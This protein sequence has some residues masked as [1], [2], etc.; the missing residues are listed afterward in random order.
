MAGKDWIWKAFVA[1]LCGTG[2][3]A[4]LMY[5]KSRSGLLPLFRPYEALQATLG[6]L[7]GRDVPAAVPWLLSW[8]N[9]SAVLGFIFGRVYPL[10]PG[11]NGATKGVIYGF[12]GWLVM[13]LVFFPL[14]SLGPF[15]LNVG[16]GVRP[17]LFSMAMFMTYSVVLGLVYSALKE[18]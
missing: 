5:F 9:G 11:S 4:L 10:I 12:F 3:H 16:L 8:L 2:A 1:G 6:Q 13:N 15:A 17:A 7:V 18:L 14:L